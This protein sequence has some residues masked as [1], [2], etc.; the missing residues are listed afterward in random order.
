M[1]TNLELRQKITKLKEILGKNLE[2][3]DPRTR[4][5][6]V[7]L[8]EKSKR[9][10]EEVKQDLSVNIVRTA[11]LI[12]GL[13]DANNETLRKVAA[14]NPHESVSIDF[15]ELENRILD[16]IYSGREKVGY[17]VNNEFSI[18]LNRALSVV[19]D[20]LGAISM[21]TVNIPAARYGKYES[22]QAVANFLHD[23]FT[24]QFG[25]ELK[26]KYMHLRLTQLGKELLDGEFNTLT[27]VITNIP[28]DFKDVV[29][30]ITNHMVFVTKEEGIP[31]SVICS[32]QDSEQDLIMKIVAKIQ[33]NKLKGEIK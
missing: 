25:T 2:N 29:S 5:G 10:L 27:I 22:K 20:E 8:Q 13:D 28:K 4:P 3:W 26:A 16:T 19:R 1:A 11:M 9:E 23:V 14:M 12:A 24:K 31:K 7:G 21:P 18:L 30:G 32:D 17:L 15:Y 6:M 33:E